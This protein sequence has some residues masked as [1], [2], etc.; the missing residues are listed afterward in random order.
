MEFFDKI[1]KK[2]SQTYKEATEKTGKLAKEAKLKML[3]SDDKSKIEEI[4]EQIGKKVYEKHI[5]EED[6]SIKEEL[7]EECSKID[8]LSDEIETARMDILH[9]KDRKQCPNCY[10]EIEKEYHFCPNCGVKQEEIPEEKTEV[11]EVEIVENPEEETT[12]KEEE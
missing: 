11:K 4:Y 2:A 5:R 9:L 6:I 8:V 7:L 3:I 12:E 10:Y 1:G